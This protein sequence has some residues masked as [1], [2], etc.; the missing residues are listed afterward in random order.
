MRINI[1]I[2]LTA[3]SFATA[4]P[5]SS[6]APASAPTGSSYA[7]GFEMTRS[8]ANLS[9]YKDADSFGVPKGVPRRCELSQVHVLHRHA[10]RYPTDY[11]LDGEGM[12]DFAAKLANFSK[13]HGGKVASGPLSFL[14]DWK[15]LL[16]SDTLMET[17]AATEA[18]SGANFWI[19]YGRL[20]YRPD[21]D[22]V[23]AWDES[24]NVYPNGT[25]RPKPVFRTT[26]QARILESARW[27][28][29]GF[30]GNSGANSS[31]E[32]YDLVIIPEESEY[33]N[34]LASY[35]SCPGDMTEG[36][37]SAEVFIPRYTKD[38]IARLS[39][40][41]PNDFN[42]T[43]YDVL[44]MQNLCAY[45][46]TSFGASAFCTLFT[47]QEW[48]D[49]AYNVD[50]QYYGDYAYGSPTGRAQGIS[51]VLELAARL[52]GHLITSSDTSINATLDNHTETF[53]LGQPF[54]M[55]M[56]HDDIILSVLSALGLEYFNF[57]PDGLPGDVDH[58][59]SNRTF[60]LSEL[61]PFGARFLSEV[62]T[63]PANV[64][65]ASLDPVL[66]SNPFIENSNGTSKYIR[67]VLNSAPLPLEGLLGCG[68]AVNGFC[69]LDR[70]LKG[71]PMLKEKAQYQEACFGDYPTGEQVRDGVPMS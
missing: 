64:S 26:S 13:A 22:H 52:Q 35:D 43:A 46:Y 27:W 62:W 63:C 20:L 65:F 25:A 41:F 38:T 17:G 61:T 6:S 9:P 37:E 19:K 47:E 3:A 71:A 58:A 7:S 1:A 34:T 48:K 21:R 5:H 16:G 59:P 33:N 14:N 66:Y 49:F 68:N 57:G 67:F 56:S 24:L 30:F 69:P 12:Q 11:P 8:W 55:D 29:S 18:T 15:Y 39:P 54:Y 70:F 28:L 42:L 40:Y 2:P 53:P 10:E 23:A 32:Q 51:Y 50:I 44:A 45:E 31:Y 60:K 36:D 4:I